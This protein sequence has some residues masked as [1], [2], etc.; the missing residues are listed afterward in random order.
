MNSKDKK[1]AKVKL[2]KT[3]ILSYG[4]IF[5]ISPKMFQISKRYVK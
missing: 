5:K 1:I 2:R 3:E 4:M